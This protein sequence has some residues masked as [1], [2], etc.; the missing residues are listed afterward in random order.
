MLNMQIGFGSPSKEPQKFPDNDAGAVALLKH[1]SSY[2][3]SKDL[4]HRPDP[5]VQNTRLVMD[6]KNKTAA[7]TYH[8]GEGD[9]E[10]VDYDK[11]R[12]KHSRTHR[13]VNE[14][15]E[16]FLED[17]VPANSAGGGQIAGIGVGPDGEPGVPAKINMTHRNKDNV[18]LIKSI[19]R[20]KAQPWWTYDRDHAGL[21]D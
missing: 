21:E 1:H 5:S 3:L 2:K 11:A 4:E 18:K 8:D 17:G 10:D 9:F 15:F 14:A 6:H 13:D 12:K 7:I 20:R 16:V 19:I